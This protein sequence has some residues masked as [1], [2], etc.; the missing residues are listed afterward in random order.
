MSLPEKLGRYQIVGHL[1][2]GGMAEVLLAKM[3]G[4]GGF[5][6]AVV[7]K[8]VLPHLARQRE[9]RHMFLDEA[10][11]VAALR[12]QNIVH[13]Q[14]LGEEGEELFLVMEYLAGE[15]LSGLMR[16]CRAAGEILDPVLGA[17]I[18]AEACAG[19]HAAHGFA[20]ADGV[21][22]GIVH[23]DVSPQ[24]I[25]VTYAGDVKVLDFGIAKAVDRY[26]Q[27][28]TGQ[29]KGKYSYMSPEQCL[30]EPLDRRSDIFSLGT[31][32]FEVTTGRALFRRDHELQT[33]KAICEEP[34]PRPS[35]RRRGYPAALEPICVRALARSP[36]G[37][38]Q[39]AA[40]MRRA[41]LG[42]IRMLDPEALPEERLAELMGRLFADR[43][44]EKQDMLRQVRAGSVVMRLPE[45]EADR[46]IESLSAVASAAGVASRSKGSG[47]RVLP[48]VAV[49]AIVVAAAAGATIVLQSGTGGAA[50]PT[51]LVERAPAAV[52]TGPAGGA[53]ADAHIEAALSDA[54]AQRFVVVQ[55]D[56]TPDGADVFVDG[57]LRGVTPLSLRLDRGASPVELELRRAGYRSTVERVI[58]DVD[59]RL[60]F[61]LRRGPSTDGRG[62]RGPIEGMQTPAPDMDTPREFFRFD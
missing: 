25:F 52:D 32:L 45:V 17:Y 56:T 7:V 51:P 4:P 38:F 42:A 61:A 28:T 5:E 24:N 48:L 12:H 15:S 10:R 62:P 43:I 26:S 37:R 49:A 8:R 55:V 33:L 58:P 44:A 11:I 2:T 29:M 53:A 57:T 6:R 14:E 16:R 23:R 18:V 19:L 41:L 21:A 35:E 1:A 3:L 20:D 40:D 30:T 54:G 36:E 9:F 47:R 13:V 27:T 34:I 50:G 31:V 46:S 39:T 22:Q 60:R 59:Q